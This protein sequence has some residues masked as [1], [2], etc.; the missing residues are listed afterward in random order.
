M[1]Q[2]SVRRSWLSC[3]WVGLCYPVR[4]RGALSWR[5]LRLPQTKKQGDAAQ[6]NNAGTVHKH[7]GDSSNPIDRRAAWYYT[8]GWQEYGTICSDAAGKYLCREPVSSTVIPS[9][10]YFHCS[11]LPY[12]S[13]PQ[14][15]TVKLFVLHISDCRAGYC[16]QSIVLLNYDSWGYKV[17]EGDGEFESCIASWYPHS[18]GK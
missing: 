6:L 12:D 1:V 18:Q 3:P 9:M 17:I 10:N 16:T 11:T 15:D 5:L 14:T 8:A 2:I 7:Q 4:D 13:P